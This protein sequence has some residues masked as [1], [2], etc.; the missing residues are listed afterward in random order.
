MIIDLRSDNL[1]M[2]VRMDLV[3]DGFSR[4]NE[5]ELLGLGGIGNIHEAESARIAAGQQS[6]FF[7]GRAGPSPDSRGLT[8]GPW[9]DIGSKRRHSLVRLGHGLNRKI[10]HGCECQKDSLESRMLGADIAHSLSPLEIVPEFAIESPLIAV[11]G[12]KPTS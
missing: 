9:T 8:L 10:R 2:F 7:S 11:K 3:P 5:S 4:R 12:L 1:D 6:E